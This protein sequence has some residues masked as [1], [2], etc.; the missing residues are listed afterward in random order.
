MLNTLLYLVASLVWTEAADLTAHP[1]GHRVWSAGAFATRAGATLAVAGMVLALTGSAALAFAT[2]AL[3]G[4]VVAAGSNLKR[5]HLGEPLVF[6]DLAYLGAAIRHPRLYIGVLPPA[7]RIGVALLPLLVLGVA[8]WGWS[9][10]PGRHTAGLV[11]LCLGVGVLLSALRHLP[12]VPDLEG[13]VGRNG[14]FATLLRYWI[15]WR[16]ERLVVVPPP[17]L[18]L[19]HDAADLVIV[20]QCESFVDPADLPGMPLELPALEAARARAELS[21]QL[22]IE[23]F[24]AYTMR[25]EFGVLTGF[26][27][28]ELGFRRYDPFVRGAVAAPRALATRFARRGYGTQFVHPFE[29]GFYNRD[30]LMPALGFETLAGRPAFAGAALDGPYVSD[31]AVAAELRARVAAV[32][33]KLFLYAVTMENHGPWAPPRGETALHAYRRHPRQQRCDAG[34]PHGFAGPDSATDAS[35]VLRGSSSQHPGGGRAGSYPPHALCHPL[36]P[37]APARNGRG[38]DAGRPA[39][40][41]HPPCRRRR[42]D[43]RHG[44]ATGSRGGLEGSGNLI[45]RVGRGQEHP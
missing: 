16:R 28:S 26:G 36:K 38:S 6:S 42:I 39:S 32:P 4:T 8:Y 45:P 1:H 19:D 13:D 44:R 15:C 18:M 23:G 5:R 43:R 10:N 31:R 34:R 12:E 33:G 14:L 41:R 3:A 40:R 35:G 2:T 37:A 27:E 20:V 11:A 21:G 29:L 24:G 7:A 25:T 30:R 22:L 9:G 17:P